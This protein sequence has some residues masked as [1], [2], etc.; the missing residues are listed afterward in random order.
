MT[1]TAPSYA[2]GACAIPLLGET[3]GANLKR[4]AARVPDAPA[5]ISCHQGCATATRS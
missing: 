5:L 1:T 3:I 2:H 4:T